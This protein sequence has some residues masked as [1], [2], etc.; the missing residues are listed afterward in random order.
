RE[1]QPSPS[2]NGYRC[3]PEPGV[4]VEKLLVVVREQELMS[5]VLMFE[6]GGFIESL[7]L[8][9]PV[10]QHIAQSC[11]VTITCKPPSHIYGNTVVVRGNQSNAAAV[12]YD[13]CSR[14][15]PSLL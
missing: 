9:S 6:C 3:V 13:T 11:G 4:T 10:V 15:P 2:Y 7:D 1:G 14:S 5:L 12:K 8:G